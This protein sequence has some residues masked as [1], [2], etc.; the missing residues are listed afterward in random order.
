MNAMKE[1]LVVYIPMDRRHAMARAATLS[2]RTAGAALFADISGF[3]SLAETLVHEL[4]PQRGAE[5]LTRYLN[6]IYDVII[7]HVHEYQGSVI[8]F[9]GDAITCWMDGDDGLRSVSC[10]LAMQRAMQRIAEIRTPAGSVVT[11]SIKVAVAAG[12]AR[13]F[14]VGDPSIRLIDALAGETMVRLAA[15]E[16]QAQQGEVIVDMQT[17]EA[18]KDAVQFGTIRTNPD[19]RDRFGVVSSLRQET[20][21]LPWSALDVEAISLHDI[22]SWLLPSVYENITRGLEEFL[23]ELRPTVALFLRFSGIDYDADEEA[24]QK[25][26]TYIRWVQATV[27]NYGAT[28]VDLNI[29]DK[30]SYIYINVGAPVAYE[31]NT[32]LAALTALALLQP[33]DN[34]AHIEPHQIGISQGR[35]RAGVYGGANHRTY[36]VLGDEVNLAARLMMAAKPGQILVS[37]AA[38]QSIKQAF[39]FEALPGIHVKGKR[40]PVTVYSL[41]GVEHNQQGQGASHALPMVGRTEQLAQLEQLLADVA[42]D[43]GQ[44][45]GLVG[46]AGIGKSRLVAEVLQLVKERVW[47]SHLGAC[48]SHGQNSSYLVWRPIWRNLFALDPAASTEEQIESVSK[49]VANLDPQ[50]ISRI[51][52]LDVVLQLP[53]PDNDL[54]GSL[55]AKIRK[56]SL[57]ALL[58]DLLLAL[59]D[60]K[61]TL[62]VLDDCQWMD[63]LSSELLHDVSHSI[64]DK[65]ICL[66]LVSRESPL[67]SLTLSDAAATYTELQLDQFSPEEAA[68]LIQ[69]QLNHLSGNT[70]PLSEQLAERLVT[71]A[72][73]NPFYLEELIAYLYFQGLLNEND[74]DS[75]QPE[76]PES[77]HRLVLSRLDQLP[78]SQ[79]VTARVAS[80]VGRVYRAAWLWGAYPSLGDPE[81][82]RMDLE[83]L[84]RQDLTERDLGEPE[85]TYHF[86]QLLTQTVTYDSLPYAMRRGIHEQ[87]GRFI[88]TT[89]ADELDNYLDLLAHHYGNSENKEKQIH[90][91]LRAGE[92]AQ[93]KYN[94]VAAIDYFRRLLPMLPTG[95]RIDVQLKLGQVLELTGQ[96]DE[97]KALYEKGLIEVQQTG[98]RHGQAWCEMALGELL[99]K[100]GNFDEAWNWLNQAHAAFE[101]SDDRAGIGQVLHYMGTMATQQGAY[102]DARLCYQKSLAIRQQLGDQRQAAYLLGNLG[103]VAR[104]QG[105][106]D[107]ARRLYEESLAIRRGLGDRWGIANSLNNLGNLTV[108]HGDL[109]TAYEQLDE[110]V[111]IHR[112]LGDR[113]MIGNALNNLGNVARAQHD[114]KTAKTL[115]DESLSIYRQ[116][117]DKWALAYLLED[118]GILVAQQGKGDAALTLVGAAASL[119]EEIGAPLTEGEASKLNAALAPALATLNA[120]QQAASS[121]AG[122]AMSLSDAVDYAQ[123]HT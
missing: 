99:H 35:M 81:E 38:Q 71:Q 66:L 15:A 46:E 67:S 1:K 79:R 91:L 20:A 92:A 74:W 119:R 77:L 76:L 69:L 26:D 54:T 80:V 7:D 96:W 94:N 56:T 9:A 28:F 40:D 104:R 107:E 37:Q 16:H 52:L 53:I 30:G 4:G 49:Q 109:V 112:Q 44:I 86:R 14:C 60:S 27:A 43:Q 23:A 115:Y 17:M 72:Q 89:Y 123:L 24:G 31:N 68:Q 111:A 113:W 95:K 117:G 29:G 3:T 45:V 121:E 55:D 11:I 100:Q 85:Q 106:P 98:D 21:L 5:E 93:A 32:E 6:L 90:Y 19:S 97:A 84:H 118:V 10:G 108:D 116:L 64:S 41:I 57:H 110:A 87:I 101:E 120:D 75:V 61:P 83:A 122:K 78:E 13:R 18:L 33:P 65:H 51:P 114:H 88:E 102:E 103:I 48:E 105:E 8:A 59:T 73:G 2:N 50:W 25:L 47:E 70:L 36:G 39:V 34:L 42:Q 63:P 62:I 12:P 58:V 82:V 22:R